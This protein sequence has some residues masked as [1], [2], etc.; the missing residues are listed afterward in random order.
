MKAYRY[1]IYPSRKQTEL[2]NHHLWLS[3]EL[4]NRLLAEVKAQYEKDKTF[5]SKTAL[6]KQV[7]QT[8][9]YSQTAQEVVK[10]LYRGLQRKTKMKK[11]GKNAGFP[12][13]KSFSQLKSLIYPQFGFSLDQRLNVTP[14]GSIA[15]KKHRAVQ[16]KIKTLTIKRESSGKWYAIFSVEEELPIP[17]SNHGPAIGIDLGLMHFGTLSNGMRIKNPQ[18]L[19]KWEEKLA[20][21]QRQLSRKKKGS[22]NRVH[23]RI[24]VARLHEK[25]ANA[26]KDFL[27]KT[28]NQLL[29]NYSLIGLE[30]LRSQE[31]AMDGHGKNIHD[32]AW[33]MFTHIL[34]CKAESAGCQVVFVNPKNTSKACSHCGKIV[35][36]SLYE[37][38]HRCTHCGLSIDRD[39]NAA[40]NIL[41]RATGGRPGSNACGDGRVIPS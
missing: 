9:L 27:H 10:R 16:G 28:A 30:Q 19:K 39:W 12:R 11:Q 41:A 35:E 31:M 5:P 20:F 1:R 40:I 3:K 36:K 18:H 17:K 34:G 15:I 4:W 21:F 7:K 13:F 33:G 29:S 25:V 37:R 8:G 32:V 23:A 14:F 38:V 2:L 6:F 26:R 22:R 24:K